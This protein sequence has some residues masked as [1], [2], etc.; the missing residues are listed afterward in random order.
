VHRV[1]GRCR[2]QEL[3]RLIAEIGAGAPDVI[4]LQHQT[5][6][7][8]RSIA[9]T[10]F[11]EW[12]EELAPASAPVVTLHDLNGPRV[13]PR[14]PRSGRPALRRLASA[15][16]GVVVTNELDQAEV[17]RWGLAREKVCLIPVGPTIEPS[18]EH[19]MA[20]GLL[21]ESLGIGEGETL[22]VH[23]GLL[24]R[25]KGIGTIVE[26]A[27]LVPP[28]AWRILLLVTPRTPRERRWREEFRAR[29]RKLGVAERLIW[30]ED[31]APAEV[32]RHLAAS[33]VGL[34][35]YEEGLTTRR[36]TFAVMAAHGLAIITTQPRY[37]PRVFGAE[38]PALFVAP[39]NPGALSR[40]MRELAAAGPV[41]EDL[42]RRAL[43][44]ARRLS[45]EEC[46][47]KTEMLYREV[48]S[49][50]AGTPRADDRRHEAGG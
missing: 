2:A 6:L 26:A 24:M 4:H 18:A 35:P 22:F 32:S 19:V 25:D 21:R 20:G 9:I 46:A 14:V 42:R 28:G 50:G 16:R 44:A 17:L 49:R 10:R 8:D 47:R 30:R 5:A 45:W 31:L 1:I 41:R 13:I 27:E 40:A 29:A 23:F 34:L 38:S 15:A 33:D 36:S 11:S 12:V 43:A 3:R 7:Y 48:I 37:W 39:R